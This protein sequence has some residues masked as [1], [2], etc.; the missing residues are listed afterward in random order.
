MAQRIRVTHLLLAGGLVLAAQPAF[1][2]EGMLFKNLLEGVVGGKGP[3]SD[4]DYRERAPLVVP[5]NSALPRPQEPGSTRSAAWPTDPD[6]ERRRNEKN[7]TP[8][9]LTEKARNNPLLTQEELRRGRTSAGGPRQPEIREGDNSNYDNQI[10]PIRV[11][12]EVAAHR[13]QE[14][15]D[16]LAYG[17]EPPR[18]TLTEP[19]VGYRLPSASA[20]LGPGRGGPVEDK[21]AVGQR[22][23]VTGQ[24]PVL[25]TPTE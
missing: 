22:E 13:N 5:P 1:A 15:E 2:Q 12:K 3:G 25:Q 19:P 10:K 16:T 21:Q 4:I 20:A 23:F 14:A 8:Y 18:R 6:V 7:V 17:S 24:G 9:V 11:G